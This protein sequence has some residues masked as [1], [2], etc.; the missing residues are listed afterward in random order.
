MNTRELSYF[1]VAYEHKNIQRAANQLCVSAQALSKTI[2]KMERELDIKLFTRVAT[3]IEPTLYAEKLKYRALRILHEFDNI[4][5]DI[6]AIDPEI[7]ITLSVAATYG[8]LRYLTYDFIKNFHTNYPNIHLNIVEF[9]D[10]PVEKMIQDDEVELGF[11]SSPLNSTMFDAEYCTSHRYCLII[12][13]DHPLS[14]KNAISYRDLENIPLAI[15]GREFSAFFTNINRFIKSGI[16]PKILIETSEEE[17]IYEF[18]RRND[19]I[20]VTLD[21]LACSNQDSNTVIRPFQDNECIRD[22]YLVKKSGKLL[23][24]EALFFKEFT[25]NWLTVNKANLF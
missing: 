11:L 6:I 20:G 9:P 17:I 2:Q 22:I 19:G 23:T 5:N 16:T 4:R 12:N 24:K 14:L 10:K 1:L 25:L 3:G 7:N 18:A 8:I 21:F 13:K 15:K